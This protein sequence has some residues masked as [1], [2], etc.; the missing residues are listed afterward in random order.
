VLVIGDD[1]SGFLFVAVVATFLAQ[2]LR[3]PEERSIGDWAVSLALPAYL[4]VL[5]SYIVGLRGNPSSPD[6]APNGFAWT[7]FLLAI[8]WANDSAAYAGGRLAGRRPFFPS[9]SPHKTLEGFATGAVATVAVGLWLH[10][11]G[12][13]PR[14]SWP[15]VVEWLAPLS[16]VPRFEIALACILV[17]LIA[18]MG[19]LSKSFL[20]RQAG[21]K[22]SGDLIPGHGGVL[23][24]IDSLLFAAPIVVHLLAR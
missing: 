2:I 10:S 11:L 3:K 7:I 23:D 1:V 18:P 22:D 17:A 21:A 6:N 20:K 19:D 14:Q 13:D 9:V 4:G 12:G 16:R 15:A 24:R 5:G 8:V